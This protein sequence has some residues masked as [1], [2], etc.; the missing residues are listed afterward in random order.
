M[1]ID[2]RD[3]NRKTLNPDT[4]MLP[5]I[6]DTL[7]ALSR[8]KYFCTL[9]ILQGYHNVELADSAKEKTAFHAPYC[10]PSHW[11]YVYMPF[12]LVRA[13]RTFQRLMDRVL[14]GLDHKIAL[15]YIDDIIVYGA[16]VDEVLDNVGVVLG[17][18]TDAGVKLKAKKCFLL[19]KETTYLGSAPPLT[20]SW[21][22]LEWC[23][24]DSPTP[25]LS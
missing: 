5:R 15:A 7:D 1:C 20:K 9:D 18:L 3:L 21:I 4:Y 6:D 25:E 8:A 2:Y 14:Q 11:E 13:P 19:Q 10:N 24:V 17:R 23:W 12:G 22:I 16:T